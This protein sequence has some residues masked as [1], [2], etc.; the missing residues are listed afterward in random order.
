VHY[1]SREYPFQFPILLIWGEQDHMVAP[2]VG[3]QLKEYFGKNAELVIIPNTGHVPNL[4]APRTFDK[5][6]TGFL[7]K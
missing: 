5:I 6:L 2:I 4:E 3:K 7:K 1:E